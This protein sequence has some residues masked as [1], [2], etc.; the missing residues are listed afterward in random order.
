MKL[1]AFVYCRVAVQIMVMLTL[2]LGMAFAAPAED[3]EHWEQLMTGSMKALKQS[4]LDESIRL[5]EQALKVAGE[6]GTNDTHL[7]RSLTFRAE[8]YLWEKKN[9]LAEQ[10]FKAA[11]ASCEKAVGTN[12]S[13][14]VH[15]LS[16]LANYYYFV[17]ARYDQVVPLFQ[18]ILKIVENTPDRNNRDFIMWSRNLGLLYQQMGQYS[19]AEP[20]FQQA[21]ALAEKTDAEWLPHELLTFADFY[22]VWGKYEQAEALATR[23]LAIRE[24]ALTPAGGIDA[25][26]DLAVSLDG[27]GAIYLAWG[28][29]GKAESSYRRSMGI[30]EKFMSPE[31][32]DLTP[33]LTGLAAALRAEGKYDQADPLY[34][35]ALAIT[36]KNV[37]TN[38]VEVAA[39]LEKR[40]ALL[41]D[42]K[43]P[44]EAQALSARAE[45]IRK[46]NAAR[47]N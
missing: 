10:T 41:K 37:G 4:H 28:R 45:A 29:P 32:A 2:G 24:K 46:Q 43:K 8:I 16:S 3:V 5:C 31:Q 44:G 13:A 39:I 30:I 22:R 47:T 12:G 6:F 11:V 17:V 36:E 27:L 25:Q 14:V 26:L 35:R 38:E 34:E 9:D 42:M 18:R 20:L 19:K 15:P 7:A 21:V 23:A 1:C 40:A 33:R